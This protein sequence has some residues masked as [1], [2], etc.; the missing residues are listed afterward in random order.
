MPLALK[1]KVAAFVL[2]LIYGVWL[3]LNVEPAAPHSSWNC[4]GSRAL[5]YIQR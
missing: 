1:L 5:M 3:A 2:V 4:A